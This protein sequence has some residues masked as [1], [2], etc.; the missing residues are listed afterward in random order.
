VFYRTTLTRYTQAVGWIN[1]DNQ[2]V[3]AAAGVNDRW[4]NYYQALGQYRA[5][6]K[7]YDNLPAEMQASLRIF[8]ITSTIFIYDFT[9][10]TVDLHGDIPWSEAG[11]VP[12]TNSYADA[13]A[14]YDDAQGIY[15]KML[16]DL[17]LFADE[18]N[19]MVISPIAV[20]SFKSADVINGGDLTLWKKYCNSLRIKL[21]S[22]VSGVAALQA[23]VNTEIASIVGSPTYPISLVNADNIAID[24]VDAGTQFFHSRDFRTGLED[25]GGNIAGK[26]MISHMQTNV[27]PRL[28]VIFEPGTNANGTYAGVDQMALNPVSQELI[29][30]SRVS[31]Y[32]RSTLSRNQLFPGLLITAAEVNFYLSEYYMKAGNMGS[33]KTHYENGIRESINFYYAVR[34]LSNNSDAIPLVPLAANEITTYLASPGV[35][36]DNAATNAQRIQLIGTQKWIHYNVVMPIENWSEMRRL[37][38]PVLVYREDPNSTQR[39]LPFRMNIPTSEVTLNA[40]NY[41]AVQAKDNLTTKIFWDVN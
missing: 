14:K 5:L 9:A 3:P 37:D 29:D 7:Q 13:Y 21:L 6:Q 30:S 32:N 28:R 38:A 27:D 12:L 20:N 34:A 17:K 15:V 2:Y 25:W 18:L 31:I 26:A 36:W 22:R 35:A 10:R 19:A 1:E 23:R 16:D 40:T 8:M 41:Q 39:N 11:K 24:V 4:G 33:A